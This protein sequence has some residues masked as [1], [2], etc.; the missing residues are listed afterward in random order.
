MKKKNIVDGNGL[1]YTKIY[2]QKS[3]LKGHELI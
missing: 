3:T 2:F 1:T